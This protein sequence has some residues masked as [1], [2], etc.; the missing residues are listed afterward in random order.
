MTTPSVA[1]ST[2][3]PRISPPITQPVNDRELTGTLTFGGGPDM[4][5]TGRISG[6][7]N[8][9][10]YVVLGGISSDRNIDGQ[11]DRQGWWSKQI[12]SDQALD[13]KNNR[14]L[15]VDFLGENISPFPS[16]THQAQAILALADEAGIDQFSI[17]GASYGGMIALALAVL[18]PDRVRNVLVISA[19]HR[20]CAMAQAWR[21]IQRDTVVLGLAHGD[22]RGGL[23]LARRLAMTTYRTPTEI[24]DRFYIPNPGSRDAQGVAAYLGAR[25]AAYCDTINAHRFLALSRSMDDHNIDPAEITCPV[26]YLAIHEDR[27][28]P[29]EQIA[30]AAART[31]HGRLKAVR[32]IYG[33]DAFLKE[34]LAI[35]DALREFIGA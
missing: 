23:D 6:P 35:A 28:V 15:S 32:S 20:S 22:A 25:G 18:A 33:H 26:T 29:I 24:E 1:L 27:L 30:E 34:D 7:E 4:L 11:G 10:V 31:P 5:I 21:S 3:P 17:I 9:P 14:V 16:T 13:T 2:P 19:A 8:A 12:G